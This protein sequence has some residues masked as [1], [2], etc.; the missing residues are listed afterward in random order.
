MRT[1]IYQRIKNIIEDENNPDM[2]EDTLER[3]ILCAYW[4]GCED[5]A[6]NLCDKARLVF[7]EQRRRAK[8][9]RY[10]N[11]AAEVIG[12]IKMLYSPFYA[13]DCMAVFGND[14][15]EL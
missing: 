11:M 5:E 10:H 7:D 14:Y 3:L 13:G 1:T 2:N 12:D 8:E 15:T 9:C 6:R 4:M